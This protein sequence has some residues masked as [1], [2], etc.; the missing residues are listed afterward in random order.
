M[1]SIIPYF[2]GKE[3]LVATNHAKEKVIA[4][5]FLN[6]LKVVVKAL[7]FL[8]TDQFGTYS[9]EVERTLTPVQA[10]LAKCKLAIKEHG[11]QMAIATEGSFGS[12]PA[13]FF[14]RAHEEVIVL[15]DATNHTKFMAKQLT[16][17]T[18]Y[19]SAEVNDDVEL[20]CFAANVG[21]PDHGLI[22]KHPKLEFG[23][24]KGI[25]CP[26]KLESIC[27][28]LFRSEIP[29]LVETDMRAM[30][31]PTR[32]KVISQVTQKLI[33]KLLSPCP[34]C[35]NPGFS[36]TSI[37]PGLPCK[38]CK[39]PTKSAKNIISTCPLCGYSEHRARPDKA[40]FEDPMYCDSCNP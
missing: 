40:E 39:T 20:S 29:V 1:N 9:G 27:A 10:A 13:S 21:F 25:N 28:P 37:E 38:A 34:K 32:M 36:D 18:N 3:V 31:N 8:D 5:L 15:Y 11:G 17:D 30:Y 6:N 16:T 23:V 4:P 2:N 19:C 26:D 35:N 24:V 7:P 12:H 22:V 14:V 33:D